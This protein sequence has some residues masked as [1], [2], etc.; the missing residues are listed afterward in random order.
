[1]RGIDSEP[2]GFTMNSHGL[3]EWSEPNPWEASIPCYRGAVGLGEWFLRETFDRAD[4][5]PL[6][7][8]IALARIPWV[9]LATLVSPMAMHGEPSGFEDP[10]CVGGVIR[11][12]VW[13]G[14]HRTLRLEAVYAS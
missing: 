6:R 8:R 1:V 13:I 14:Q 2:G 5:L 4:G 7:G 11:S 9:A 3:G 12:R 10:G